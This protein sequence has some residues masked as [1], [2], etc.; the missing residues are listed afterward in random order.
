MPNEHDGLDRER[1]DN[2][3]ARLDGPRG[4]AA[5][6]N[7]LRPGDVVVLT[8]VQGCPRMTL[9]RIIEP[10]GSGVGRSADCV[11]FDGN[12]L[13]RGRFEVTSLLKLKVEENG[14]RQTA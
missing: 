11:W 13:Q 6:D 7:Q 2:T 12:L 10:T 14:A 8:I 5:L 4:Q 9:E 1:I 3:Q